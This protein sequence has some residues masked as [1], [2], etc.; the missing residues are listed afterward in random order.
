MEKAAFKQFLLCTH[1]RALIRDEY[2]KESIISALHLGTL[3]ALRKYDMSRG[4]RFFT[5]AFN[6]IRKEVQ[7]LCTDIASDFYI[8]MNT[9]TA[10]KARGEVKD[11]EVAQQVA[12]AISKSK[13]KIDH[14]KP[15]VADLVAD[16]Q[17]EVPELF[18][19]VLADYKK[20]GPNVSYFRTQYG[21]SDRKARKLV[22]ELARY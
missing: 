15:I 22:E 18:K 17:K 9:Y 5:I 13:R 16:K 7:Q 11:N 2:V 8:P 3:K 12:N 6:Y 21:L 10:H 19:M 14:S 4:T 1:N 20:H